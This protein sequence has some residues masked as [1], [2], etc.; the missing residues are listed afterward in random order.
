MCAGLSSTEQQ[1]F[2]LEDSNGQPNFDLAITDSNTWLEVNYTQL[3]A[4]AQRLLPQVKPGAI[5]MAMV[6]VRCPE[7][8]A[9]SVVKTVALIPR[10]STGHLLM[11][12]GNLLCND[13]LL[14]LTPSYTAWDVLIST[15]LRPGQSPLQGEH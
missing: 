12:Q 10:D 14:F 1:R 15:V 3:V 7:S 2:N 6:K 11:W 4:N 8:T 9:V 13:M 5:P